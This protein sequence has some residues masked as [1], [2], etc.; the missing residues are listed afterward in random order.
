MPAELTPARRDWLDAAAIDS[1]IGE[2]VPGYRALVVVGE[3]IAGGESDDASE[4]LLQRAEATGV[5]ID[6]P[7]LEA[8]RAAFRLFGANPRRTRPSADSLVRRASTGLPRIDRITDSYNAI[9][10]LHATP[11]GGEDL[12]GYEGPLLLTRAVGTESFDT[13]A[14]G[15]PVVEHPEPGEVVWKDGAGV[16]C[17]RWNWR[18]CVRTRLST[19]TT[20]AVFIFDAL[21]PVID[22]ELRAIGD[23]LVSAIANPDLRVGIRLIRA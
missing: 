7:H 5:S 17:R 14:D 15:E 6:H 20:S 8:W 12:D 3:N 21:E 2:L 13:V 9:S 18:Q 1:S 23:E 22:D 16:T 4:S 10:V 19:A 11:T